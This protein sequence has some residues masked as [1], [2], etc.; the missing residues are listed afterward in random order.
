MVLVTVKGTGFSGHSHQIWTGQVSGACI[1]M[2]H[3]GGSGGMLPP[4][5]NVWNLE[6]MRLLL[7]PFLDQNDASQRP[8]N[9]VLHA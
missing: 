6:A 8:D 5:E 4:Q 9:R 1:S 2:Q 7:R 3:L